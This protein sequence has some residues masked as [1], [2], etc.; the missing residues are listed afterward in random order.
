M[1][2]ALRET[3]TLLAGCSKAE[4]K[5]FAPPQTSFPGAWDGQN[6]I[7]W[8]PS[9]TDP[10]WYWSMHAI[11]GCHGNRPTNKHTHKQTGP[12]TI[13]CAAKLS[14]QCKSISR[15]LEKFWNI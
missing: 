12:I 4:P 9:P 1:K 8:S 5:S 2:K 13:Y 7:S 14:A 15:I 10:V 11:L 6:L 3:K